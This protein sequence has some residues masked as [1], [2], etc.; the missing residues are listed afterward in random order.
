MWIG[1]SDDLLDPVHVA[2]AEAGVTRTF[3]TSLA[4][5]HARC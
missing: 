5:E 4:L 1:N 3:R 2:V